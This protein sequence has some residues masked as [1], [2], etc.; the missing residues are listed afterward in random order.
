M[1]NKKHLSIDEVFGQDLD[2]FVDGTDIEIGDS[3]GAGGRYLL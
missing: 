2:A 1:F 3:F